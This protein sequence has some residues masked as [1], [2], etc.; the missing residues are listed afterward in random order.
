MINS[1]QNAR[2]EDWASLAK[3][4]QGFQQSDI[5]SQ[6]NNNWWF[7]DAIKGAKPNG[8]PTGTQTSNHLDGLYTLNQIGSQALGYP[9]TGIFNAPN[10][11]APNPQNKI[12]GLLDEY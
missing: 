9:Q 2:P 3:I 12:K 5:N 7:F 1:G 4:L 11:N 8:L 10:P 6:G